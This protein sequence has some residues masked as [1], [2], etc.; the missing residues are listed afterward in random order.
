MGVD[1]REAPKNRQTEALAELVNASFRD[2]K[3][4]GRRPGH[5]HTRLVTPDGTGPLEA[6]GLSLLT[7]RWA[8]GHGLITTNAAG[9]DWGQTTATAG[10]GRGAATRGDEVLAWTGDRLL[11]VSNGQCYGRGRWSEITDDESGDG[12]PAYIPHMQTLRAGLAAKG[13][14]GTQF[15]CALGRQYVAVV[16][17]VDDKVKIYVADRFT[18]A[19]VYEGD[20]YTITHGHVT[21]EAPRIVFS[22]GSFVVYWRD[23]DLTKL[24]RTYATEGAPDTWATT[25]EQGDCD[26]PFDVCYITDTRHLVAWTDGTEVKITYWNGT[27]EDSLPATEGTVLSLG[28]A[29]HVVE[30]VGVS[31][32]LNGDIGLIWQDNNAGTRAVVG[33]VYNSAGTALD[34]E[35]LFV[36]GG[37]ASYPAVAITPSLFLSSNKTE[38]AV[39][40]NNDAGSNYVEVQKGVLTRTGASNRT[41]RKH[42]LLASRAFR[43][44]AASGVWLTAVKGPSTI[45][46]SELFAPVRYLLVDD[47][48]CGFADQ[49]TATNPAAS[50]RQPSVWPDPLEG[51]YPTDATTANWVTVTSSRETIAGVGSTDD[52][53]NIRFLNMLPP[54]RSAQFGLSTYF[55][56]AAAQVYDGRHLVEVGFPFAPYVGTP[57]SANSSGSLTNSGKYRYRV[58][59]VWENAQ[60]EVFRSTA[61]TTTELTLGA[62]DDTVT[63]TIVTIPCTN[64]RNVRFEVYR[65]EWF[66]SAS[67]GGTTYH[68][69]GTTSTYND[70]ETATV[71]YIDG[72]AD[73]LF[74]S[75]GSRYPIDP[76]NPAIGQASELDEL[77]PPASELIAAHNDR[78]WLAGGDVP[79][80]AV[81][82]SKLKEPGEGAGFSDTVG[83]VTVDPAGR[84]VK[85]LA[86]LGDSL[87][88]FTDTRPL[89][90]QGNGPDN[91]GNGFF[92][93][94]SQLTGPGASTHEGTCQVEPGVLYWSVKGP[95]LLTTGF[96]VA[97][98]SAPVEPLARLLTPTG[99]A[100]PAGLREAR[101]YTA[102]GTALLWD[103]TG[104]GRWAVW[105]GIRAGGVATPGSSRPSV[106]TTDGKVWEESPDAH[107]DGGVPFTFTWRLSGIRPSDLLMGSNLVREIGLSGKY[108]G[109]HT[110]HV[111]LYYDGAAMWEQRFSWTPGTDL[112]VG[113]DWEDD[114]TV[115]DANTA[116]YN[117]PDG[118]Y[119]FSKRPAR[120]TF[121]SLSVR[122]SD[123][124]PANNSY[125]PYEFSI[126]LGAKTG[127]TNMPQRTYTE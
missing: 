30:A 22:N 58:Y 47:V 56:G 50:G 28:S 98:V 109:D 79:S 52:T 87:V 42:S 18:G 3:T 40:A 5:E 111:W 41:N 14:Y 6:A 103:Y 117:S 36:S 9:T 84:P 23:S 92:N 123:G 48:V 27:N 64:K 93:P 65:N 61:V 101:W 76:F 10:V 124:G 35:D 25:D 62:A 19:P 49:G 88:V 80:G 39:Y 82:F 107:T 57:T 13:S 66:P 15:D 4:F 16:F 17:T 110:L 69:V 125:T 114:T 34:A 104:G 7:D 75:N 73:A 70:H 83:T 59:A 91:L 20:L 105:R 96:Q 74:T 94:A 85:S 55:A 71:T 11:S 1:L 68:Y 37:C 115:W 102:D 86:S 127:L 44:G 54:L 43:C 31:V 33:R 100:A 77:S 95:R 116:T 108:H 122:F 45:F 118:V 60:G 8:Y 46:S 53:L 21:T 2:E 89:V 119:R 120:Q 67:A 113:G 32:A 90:L 106:I 72:V 12:I 26:G 121:S 24:R 97:D 63:L 81:T 126:E 51:T 112:A 99:C 78:I 38:W 29:N